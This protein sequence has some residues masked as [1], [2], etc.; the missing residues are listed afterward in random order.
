[1]LSNRLAP[2]VA[3]P[4]YRATATGSLN[5][6]QNCPARQRSGSNSNRVL[7]IVVALNRWLY[8]HYVGINGK[9]PEPTL[10]EQHKADGQQI[11]NEI[12]R[13]KLK[14]LQGDL[15]DRREVEFVVG[16]AIAALRTELLRLPLMI[17]AELRDLSYDRVFAIRMRMEKVVDDFLLEASE[18][19]S[20]A[21]DPRA[22]IAE[23][24]AAEEDGVGQDSVE[25]ARAKQ[26]LA[27]K[28]SR[29]NEKRRAKRRK[30]KAK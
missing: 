12:A 24:D 29:A 2:R 19:L 6:F 1:M 26:A 27:R 23:L 18:A 11:L 14:K 10:W 8:L 25:A 30:A 28:K 4:N 16:N 3:G 5:D 20:K 7:T 9:V 13:T 17:A 22:A 15:L 21:V